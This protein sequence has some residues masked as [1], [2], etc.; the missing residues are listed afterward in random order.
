ML[1]ICEKFYALEEKPLDRT[2]RPSP[3]LN[4]ALR[5]LINLRRVNTPEDGSCKAAELMARFMDHVLKGLQKSGMAV[6][7]EPAIS[8][9]VGYFKNPPLFAV[10]GFR[11]SARCSTFETRPAYF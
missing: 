2:S 4:K 10:N 3:A 6:D 9:M 5:S 8:T 1:N 11:L 7:K